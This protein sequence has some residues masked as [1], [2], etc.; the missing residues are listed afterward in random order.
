MKDKC[1]NIMEYELTYLQ[2]ILMKLKGLIDGGIGTWNMSL[3]GFQIK[4]KY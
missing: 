4:L 1:Q 3:G 2:I